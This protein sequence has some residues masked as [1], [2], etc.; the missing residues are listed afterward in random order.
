MGCK[1]KSG[2]SL[3]ALLMTPL[4]HDPPSSQRVPDPTGQTS[5]CSALHLPSFGRSFAGPGGTPVQGQGCAEVGPCPSRRRPRRARGRSGPRPARL[6]A[7]NTGFTCSSTGTE[8]ARGT[9]SES[10]GSAIPAHPPG[11]RSKEKH[12]SQGQ[13]VPAWP[14]PVWEPEWGNQKALGKPGDAKLRV[15]KLGGGGGEGSTVGTGNIRRKK[16]EQVVLGSL[17]CPLIH[18]HGAPFSRGGDGEAHTTPGAVAALGSGED[19]AAS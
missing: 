17:S 10:R 15:M 11:D 7:R 18:D 3:Q 5:C 14:V 16:T 8:Q 12:L 13:S 19:R 2:F 9:L 1:G 6:I 4:F